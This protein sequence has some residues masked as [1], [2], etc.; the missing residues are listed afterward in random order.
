M[1]QCG[2]APFDGRPD[3]KE[4]RNV[5]DRPGKEFNRACLHRLHGHGY[6]RVAGNEND[7]HVRTPG[8]LL[9]QFE[10]AQPWKCQVEDQ[11]A[12][13][14]ATRVGEKLLCRRKAFG[15]PA[16]C[17]NQPLERFACG[18]V[19]VNNDDGGSDVFAV[20]RDSPAS[21]V[22]A[23]PAEYIERDIGFHTI[24]SSSGADHMLSSPNFRTAHHAREA[25][26]GASLCRSF[27]IEEI[28]WGLVTCA[29]IIGGVQAA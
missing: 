28:G 18:N 15:L 27:S 1:T 17:S 21:D 7:W 10:A 19:A 12:R 11:T 4:K 16:C 23:N 20:T 3:R 5:V 8:E 14:G 2:A 6:V 29:D 26:R 24:S 13:E 25:P 22:I 9:L